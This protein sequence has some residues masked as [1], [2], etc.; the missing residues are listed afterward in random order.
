MLDTGRAINDYVIKIRTQRICQGTHFGL[1]YRSFIPGLGSRQQIH[2]LKALITDQSLLQ[3]TTPLDNIDNIINDTVFQ[4]Q[5]D[6]EISQPYIGIQHCHLLAH[7]G[8]PRTYIGSSGG[9][10]HAALAGG[11]DIYNSHKASSP[12][13]IT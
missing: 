7:F 3:P 1:R 4:P 8:Q 6:I 10:A 5:N 12:K 13:Y 2:I 11:N 9:L